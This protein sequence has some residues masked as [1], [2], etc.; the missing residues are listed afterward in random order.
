MNEA[1]LNT[2]LDD[3]IRRRPVVFIAELAVLLDTS[4]RTIL[5]QLRT[6]TFFIPEMPAVDRRHRWSREVVYR[7]IADQSAG[8]HRL[9]VLRRMR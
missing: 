7:V 6:G 9:N 2:V 5:R 1:H 3:E 4:T 8:G